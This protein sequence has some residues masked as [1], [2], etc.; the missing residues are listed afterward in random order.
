MWL[1]FGIPERWCRLGAAAPIQP[2]AWQL[3]YVTH[4]ALKEKKPK[5]VAKSHW[6]FVVFYLT[7]QTLPF[8]LQPSCLFVSLATVPQAASLFSTASSSFSTVSLKPRVL[9]VTDTN[10][11]HFYHLQPN[12]STESIHF[13]K[14]S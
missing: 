13:T 1:R 12:Y 7:E 9:T 5:L 11:N 3:P 8:S 6:L 2:L 10:D 14:I 4:A